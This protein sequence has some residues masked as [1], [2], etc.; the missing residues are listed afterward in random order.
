MIA[1]LS[2]CIDLDRPISILPTLDMLH[3]AACMRTGHV[4]LLHCYCT[5]GV[6]QQ[7]PMHPGTTQKVATLGQTTQS[8]RCYC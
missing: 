8:T 1:Q 7:R 5:H 2:P 6:M 3:I 4:P